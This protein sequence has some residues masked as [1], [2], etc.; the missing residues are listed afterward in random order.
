MD[1][2]SRLL[3]IDLWCSPCTVEEFSSTVSLIKT[4]VRSLVTVA[5]ETAHPFD[6]HGETWVAI[7]TESHCAIHTYPEHHYLSIDLYSCNPARDL[8]ALGR[9]LIK[10]IPSI[11][12]RS[13]FLDRG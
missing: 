12:I 4:R 3:A 5:Q 8:E 13:Q 1:T 6:P 11:K 10:D 7:L 2:R 9:M